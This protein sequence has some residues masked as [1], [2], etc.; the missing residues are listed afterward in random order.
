LPRA[1]IAGFA[2]AIA[3][4]VAYILAYGLA[5]LSGRATPSE[6]GLAGTVRG[7]LYRLT[8]NE[9]TDLAGS[10]LYVV[11]GLHLLVAIG[12]ALLYARYAEPRFG[13]P[14]WRRGLVFSLL[15]WLL[16][17]LV[18]LPLV[19]G[20]LLG[21]ELGAGPL[22]V[23]GNLVL[24]LAYGATLG[25]VY[26]PIGDIPADSLSRL[27]PRDTLE[28]TRRVEV[29]IAKGIGLG[30]ILGLL[31]GLAA[32]ALVAA[33]PSSAASSIPRAAFVLSWTLLGGAFGA[34]VASFAALSPPR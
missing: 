26:G 31:I 8:H 11:A 32:P 33:G 14:G 9:L 30:L 6:G 25:L 5:Y 34:F 2:A 28:T 24:H 13:G 23:V 29:Q 19:G 4:L 15:P 17:V 21:G 16:S 22:P 7:W 3:M 18:V 20:G 12:W 10:Q 1:I 27:G